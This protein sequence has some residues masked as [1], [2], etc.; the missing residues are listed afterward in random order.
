MNYV[1]ESFDYVKRSFALGYKM[2]TDLLDAVGIGYETYFLIIIGF[3]VVALVLSTVMGVF[4]G[5]A[6]SSVELAKKYY[7][8]QQ[9]KKALEL[10]KS[11]KKGD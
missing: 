1:T 6:D 10:K 8:K 5:S 9:A 11:K 7:A 4:R 3:A 2:L